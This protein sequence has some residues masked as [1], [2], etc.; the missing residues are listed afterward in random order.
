MTSPQ[1]EGHYQAQA[2]LANQPV[3]IALLREA[4]AALGAE[5]CG[6][7]DSLAGRIDGVIHQAAPQGEPLL[8]ALGDRLVLESYGSGFGWF[9]P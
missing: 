2:A 1:S 3:L 8:G 4:R 5:Y 7:Y 9:R 6:T